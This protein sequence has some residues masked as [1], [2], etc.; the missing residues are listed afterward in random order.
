MLLA[1]NSIISFSRII[2]TIGLDDTTMD[3]DKYIL[4][5]LLLELR[6]DN[7][8]TVSFKALTH[9]N[10]F[11]FWICCRCRWTDQWTSPLEL[12]FFAVVINGQ[13]LRLNKTMITMF[14]SFERLFGEDFWPNAVLLFTKRPMDRKNKIRR[15]KTGS[16]DDETAANFCK[17][18]RLIFAKCESLKY[19]YLDAHYDPTDEDEKEAFDSASDNLWNLISSTPGAKIEKPVVQYI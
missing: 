19:L 15:M 7:L 11:S 16:T 12:N 5:N 10:E 17:S 1:W 3:V 18:L 9:P 4:N 14:Q 6:K 13:S 8:G 2:D